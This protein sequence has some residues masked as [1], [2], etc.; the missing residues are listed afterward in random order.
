MNCGN[1]GNG[2]NGYNGYICTKEAFS[3]GGYEVRTARSSF[4]EPDTGDKIVRAAKGLIRRM[5]DASAKEIQSLPGRRVW[6]VVH[7]TALDGIQQINK[8]R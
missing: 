7:D 5:Y 3:G 8:K 4:L 1:G 6:P 2:Y